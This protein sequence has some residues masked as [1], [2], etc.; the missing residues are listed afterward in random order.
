MVLDKDLFLIG[1]IMKSHGVKGKMR[2]KYFGEEV[3]RFPPYRE[4]F[5]KDDAGRPQP[6]D[7]LEAI[8][9]PPHLIFLL[10]GIEELEKVHPLIGKEIYIKREALPKLEQGEHYWADILGLAVETEKGK[11]IG[12]VKDIFPSGANDV[13]VIDGKRREILIP[14]T[15]EVIREIDLKEG[16]MKVSRLEGLW[17]EED[18]V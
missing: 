1:R 16:R 18:E 17:E 7:I 6:Y 13:Y 12:R 10:K 11:K 5:I 4:V 2:V 9:Q 8:P 3:H 15:E 14:A